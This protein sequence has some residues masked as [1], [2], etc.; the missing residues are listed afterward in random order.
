M[1][2]NT[3]ARGRSATLRHETPAQRVEIG[4]GVVDGLGGIVSDLGAS[5]VGVLAGDRVWRG[6][7]GGRAA[8]SL[9]PVERVVCNDIEPHT[10]LSAAVR[11]GRRF[12]DAGVD[13]ILAIGG[14]SAS[15]LGKATAAV[16]TSLD[17]GGAHVDMSRFFA[18]VRGDGTVADP[19]VAGDPVPLVVVPTTLSG[20]ELS[21]GAGVTENGMKRVLW[22]RALA[23]RAV[24]YETSGDNELPA[25]IAATT[26]M[27]AVAHAV[28]ALYSIK[29][30]AISDA[31]AIAG[32]ESLTAGLL[33]YLVVGDRG[34]DAK[35]ELFTGAVLAGRALCTAR[36]CLH[37]AICHVLGAHHG[38]AHGAANAAMLSH[39]V[40]FNEAGAAEQLARCSSTIRSAAERV[41]GTP[42]A[43]T[44]PGAVL[45]EFETRIGA[46]TT[47]AQI[48]LP[49]VDV[50]EVVAGLREERGI[51]LNPVPVSDADVR[52]LLAAA[53]HGAA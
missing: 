1:T 2:L 34:E 44:A 32:L 51:A 4:S 18:R 33:R 35:A 28:E 5:V 46:P 29:G 25:T 37:H 8:A 45:R 15:D 49:N 38:V 48:G 42:P 53:A 26:G 39:V 23:A 12:A 24:L 11:L 52:R 47:L 13:L 16:M 22:D 31:L 30:D 36:V 3:R 9:G 6:K 41:L 43:A 50:E 17:G 7:L 21:P 20:A 19:A 40:D 10:P 14:G 27:N